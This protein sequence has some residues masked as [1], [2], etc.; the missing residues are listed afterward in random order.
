MT[1]IARSVKARQTLDD[2]MRS[3]ILLLRVY[4]LLDSNDDIRY[5]GEIV[6]ALRKITS[7]ADDEELMLIYNELFLGLVRERA[8]VPRSTLRQS[9][10]FHL[11]RQSVVA[12]CTALETYLSAL[13]RENLPVIIRVRGRDFMPSQNKSIKGFFNNLQFSIDTTLR[14]IADENAEEFISDSMIKFAGRNYLSGS[15][16]IEVTGSLLGVE[17]PQRQIADHL[18][19]EQDELM[20]TLDS[21]VRRRNDIVHRA[22]RAQSDPDGAAQEIG[23]AWTQHA[24]DTVQHVCLALDELVA[25][26]MAEILALAGE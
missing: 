11:L 1:M 17:D 26:R 15:R 4:R 3:A 18:N 6:D 14:L 23:Y 24:V 5:D 20:S 7:A 25:A 13:L 21:T 19:R 12:S 10:L 2:N 9:T 8:Q 22:D 16:G